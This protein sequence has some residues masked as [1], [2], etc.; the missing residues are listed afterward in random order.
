MILGAGIAGLGAGLA[1]AE[2]GSDF[3]MLELE[4]G[5][6]GLV[7]TDEVDGFRFDRTGHFLHFK[8]DLLWQQLQ[9]TGVPFDR[10]ERKSAVLVGQAVVPYP[11][12]Y[13]LWALDSPELAQASLA[14]LTGDGHPDEPPETFADLML[15]SW[16][17]T[18]YDIFFQPYNEKLWGRPLT[19][20]P[21]DCVG[22]YLP[23]IDVDLAVAGAAGLTEY[24]GYNGT[25]FY[26]SSGRL[27]DAADALA[28][29]LADRTCY[30]CAVRAID[31]SERLVETAGGE[32]LPY[33]T[34]IS[35][36][37]LDTFLVLAGEQPS[38]E[39]FEASEILNVRIG[40]RGSMR[41][42]HQWVYVPDA[43]LPFH[44]IGFPSNVN[45]KTCPPGCA[46]ISVEYTHPRDAAPLAGPDIADQA[47]AYLDRLGFVNVEEVLTVNELLLEPAYVVNRSP[48]RPEFEEIRRRLAEAGVTLAGRF[49]T[50][51]YL[52]IEESFD[53]GW[54]AGATV[55]EAVR[56]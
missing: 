33:E 36:L 6:G 49:A 42:P 40:F 56:V 54:L 26:P 30:E 5:P 52:S 16:G 11:I 44:R 17:R 34:L 2:T 27:G 1:L 47:I 55:R 28:A 48:G 25:F 22:G 18:L 41:K 20:L 4:D 37:P 13:N 14:E 24:G 51:D 32:T 23:T 53:S 45:P 9:E 50:W 46:S 29:P 43:E 39:L 19:D 12:Q 15:R 35:T 10:I 31:L 21:A 7:R 3:T 8:G 38:P